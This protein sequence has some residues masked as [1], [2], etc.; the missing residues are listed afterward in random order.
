M[1]ETVEHRPAGREGASTEMHGMQAGDA[2]AFVAHKYHR[3]SAVEERER[4][5]LIVE[6]WGGEDRACAHRCNLLRDH[7]NFDLHTACTDL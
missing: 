2:V 3:L 5:V 6:L 4:K 7:C 1:F